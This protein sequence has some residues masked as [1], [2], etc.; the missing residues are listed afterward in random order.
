M[1]IPLISK[2]SSLIVFFFLYSILKQVSFAQL[3]SGYKGSI[4]AS[5][6]LAFNFNPD[7]RD[8]LKDSLGLNNAGSIN[9]V[10]NGK[11]YFANRFNLSISLAINQFTHSNDNS[12]YKVN[13]FVETIGLGWNQDFGNRFGFSSNLNLGIYISSQRYE[14]NNNSD[15]LYTVIQNQQFDV[16]FT[17]SKADFILTHDIKM[18]CKV[19]KNI[20]LYLQ[21]SFAY[22]QLGEHAKINGIH[23]FTNSNY[24]SLGLTYAVKSK[25]S[26]SGN[27]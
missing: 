3:Y 25:R 4:N 14:M 23:L 21:Y 27:E 19:Y 24:L 18:D 26:I 9:Y 5:I 20:F 13:Q 2:S 15:D 12:F 7:A 10:F 16:F 17:R 11:S 1:P 6:G 8:F 22:I